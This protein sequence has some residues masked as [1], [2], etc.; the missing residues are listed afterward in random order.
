MLCYADVNT[1]VHKKKTADF[2]SVTFVVKSV[3][4]CEISMRYEGRRH[5][6]V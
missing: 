3:Y 6:Y 4:N 5:F 1:V 2:L